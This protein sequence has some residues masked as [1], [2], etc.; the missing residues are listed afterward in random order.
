[1]YLTIIPYLMWLVMKSD[2]ERWVNTCL[3]CPFSLKKINGP[4]LNIPFHEPELLTW[5]T[6]HVYLLPPWKVFFNT[7]DGTLT[8]L[9]SS[10]AWSDIL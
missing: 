6:N 2:V 1:M 9:N 5:S 4:Y 8:A 10:T 7:Y 3:K